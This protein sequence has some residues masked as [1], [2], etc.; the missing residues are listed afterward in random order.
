MPRINLL[1]PHT[2]SNEMKL[3]DLIL[4]LHE[5]YFSITQV[6]YLEKSKQH[7]DKVLKNYRQELSYFLKKLESSIDVNEEMFSKGADLVK[8]IQSHVKLLSEKK[9]GE[10]KTV[11]HHAENG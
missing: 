11:F 10:S 6:F 8:N 2:P 7:R 5:L 4:T 9:Y 1:H 3:V